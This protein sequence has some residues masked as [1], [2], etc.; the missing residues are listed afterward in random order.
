MGTEDRTVF[1]LETCFLPTNPNVEFTP[2]TYT[3]GPLK[4]PDAGQSITFVQGLQTLGGHGDPTLKEGLAVH[5]YSFNADM[6]RQAFVNNDGELLIV[7][8]RG[9]L[10]I[11]TELGSLRVRPGAIAVIPAGIRFA[12][13]IVPGPVSASDRPEP[14]SAAGYALEIFGSHFALPELGVL[15]GNGLARVR[16]FE[17]PVA[18]FDL[19]PP[20]SATEGAAPSRPPWKI[21]I[22]LAGK[23]YAYAQAHT[24]FDVVAWHGRYAP[25]KYELARF[26]HLSANSDQL[27]PTA[28]TVLTA[29]SK[30]PG[31]SLI[32]FCIFGEKWVIA[33]KTIRIPYYHRT[34]ATELVGVIKGQYRGSVRPLEPGGLSF[35]QS[36]M[37]HGESYD[38]WK[39]DRESEHK[40]VKA[41]EGFLGMSF[42]LPSTAL[43]VR[44]IQ[45]LTGDARRLHVPHLVPR[46]PD[47][48]GDRAAS[49]HPP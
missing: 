47:Q 6:K 46:R 38:A 44:E 13:C 48:V 1:K 12:V 8:H 45:M 11:Q 26:A 3:W 15:G 7:P 29:P 40:P 41:A 34:M 16:D 23:L 49:R 36:Y 39:K 21:T 10:D 35:E 30:W 32:D 43:D 22:K 20:S 2:H 31:V 25:Y 42:L 9:A 5:Q 27:D 37:P 17:Y 24:P 19:D 33:E 28:Y 14:V 4:A 18:G